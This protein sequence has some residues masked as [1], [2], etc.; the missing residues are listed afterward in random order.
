MYMTPPV[1]T[2][3]QPIHEMG[4]AAARAVLRALQGPQIE[5]PTLPALVLVV[6]GTTQHPATP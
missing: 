5:I 6:R 2:V 4:R 1:T 3:R